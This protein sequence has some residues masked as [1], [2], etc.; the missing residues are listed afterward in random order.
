MSGS[1]LRFVIVLIILINGNYCL[2]SA[3]MALISVLIFSASG[4]V[5]GA[6]AFVA[7][8]ASTEGDLYNGPFWPHAVMNRLPSISN[9][10]SLIFLNICASGD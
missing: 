8:L 9:K 5:L 10:N 2:F 7:W 6:S 1:L 3:S 4:T